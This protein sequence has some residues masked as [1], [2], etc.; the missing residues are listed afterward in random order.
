M[1]NH[2]SITIAHC[3]YCESVLQK[4]DV[5]DTDVC[6]DCGKPWTPV[7]SNYLFT[8]DEYAKSPFC[9]FSGE[10]IDFLRDLIAYNSREL[11]QIANELNKN[12]LPSDKA[13]QE[14]ALQLRQEIAA[15]TI[16]LKRKLRK[17]SL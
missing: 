12:T 14:I 4:Q 3:K 15:A 2:R 9:D 11:L 13:V 5:T 7:V 17:D 16:E 8:I 6:A 10:T 1:V